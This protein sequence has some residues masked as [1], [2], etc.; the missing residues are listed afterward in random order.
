MSLPQILFILPTIKPTNSNI[1]NVNFLYQYQITTL[2]IHYSQNSMSVYKW[3]QLV[4]SMKM[5]EDYKLFFD[6]ETAI[7]TDRGKTFFDINDNG[8]KKQIIVPNKVCIDALQHA[9]TYFKNYADE[10]ENKNDR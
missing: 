3:D 10:R 1:L 4:D 2:P 8:V 5:K 9:T 6:P 7:T